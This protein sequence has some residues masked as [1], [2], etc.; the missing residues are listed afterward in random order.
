MYTKVY[1]Q[2]GFTFKCD[3]LHLQAQLGLK[4]MVTG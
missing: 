1:T 3:L 2:A 4:A